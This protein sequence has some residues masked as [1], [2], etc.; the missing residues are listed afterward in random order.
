VAFPD[1]C[2]HLRTRYVALSDVK[3][4]FPSTTF[5]IPDECS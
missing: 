3:H 4:S 5:I 1:L 2:R